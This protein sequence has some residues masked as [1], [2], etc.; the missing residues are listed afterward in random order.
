[1]GNYMIIRHT[2]SDFPAWKTGYEAHG[3]ARTAAG[4]AEKHLLQ[5]AGNP[6]QVTIIL[7]ADDL[8]RAEEF[9]ASDDLREAMQRV[10]VV[11]QPDIYFCKG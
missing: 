1:M 10:G 8:Q 5:D 11:G 4:L 2:V 7:E 9:S 3:P 6:N